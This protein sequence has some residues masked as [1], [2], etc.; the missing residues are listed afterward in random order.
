MAGRGSALLLWRFLAAFAEIL[1]AR[2]EGAGFRALEDGRRQL[3]AELLAATGELGPALLQSLA[4]LEGA[5]LEGGVHRASADLKLVLTSPPPSRVEWRSRRS[6]PCCWMRSR[7][8]PT[9]PST[10]GGHRLG[11]GDLES[12]LALHFVR[13]DRGAGGADG[14][15]FGGRVIWFERRP[16]A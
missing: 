1:V 3:Q 13:G 6:C 12:G 8:L 10:A 5:G 16:S 2:G 14:K 9:S 4:K 15:C 7:P 11:V